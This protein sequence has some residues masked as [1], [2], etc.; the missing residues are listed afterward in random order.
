MNPAISD[1]Y[2]DAL[3]AQAREGVTVD[4]TPYAARHLESVHSRLVGVPDQVFDV[5]REELRDGMLA[6][7]DVRQLAARVDGLLSDGQRW[8]NRATVIARTEVIGANNSGGYDAAGATAAALGV[9]PAQVFKEWLSTPGTRTRESHKPGK[10]AGVLGLTTPFQ[11]GSALLDYPGMPG[12]PAREVVQ[13][14]CSVQYLMPGDPG[15][16]EEYAALAPPPLAPAG[17]L[18]RL[19]ASVLDDEMTSLMEAGDYG[20]RFA[21]LMAEM[22]RRDSA[23][24]GPVP[25]E[26]SA[27]PDPVA[28][29]AALN[30]ILF[31]SE[32]PGRYVPKRS[33]KDGYWRTEEQLHDE[34]DTW[35]YTQWLRAEEECRGVMLSAEGQRAG[36]DVVDLFTRRKRSLKYASQELQEWFAANQRMS[37]SEFRAGL[38]DDTAARR[39]NA[40]RANRGWESEWG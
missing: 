33:S 38:R 18:T 4:A 6:G 9:D 2:L 27:A 14:R 13:C 12:G 3:R 37:F 40:S 31:G 22:D 25:V 34:Y 32:D 7:D 23:A 8:R 39:A 15:Y 30:K 35:V 11:V 1:A 21:A 17:D 24:N 16:P 5:M 28:E 10:V 36:V 26:L 29:Q 20:P 19:D